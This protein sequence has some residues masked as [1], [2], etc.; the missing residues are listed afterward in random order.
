MLFRHLVWINLNCDNFKLLCPI[1]YHNQSIIIMYTWFQV[2]TLLQVNGDAWRLIWWWEGKIVLRT[3]QGGED[4]V[5]WWLDLKFKLEWT[6]KP[7]SW[8][9]FKLIMMATGLKIW[10]ND[11]LRVIFNE[12]LRV[13]GGGHHDQPEY[14]QA[15][16][17]KLLIRL[18][19]Q[20]GSTFSSLGPI[21]SVTNYAMYVVSYFNTKCNYIPNT[22][23]PI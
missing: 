12:G 9:G 6:L 3:L 20:E 19:V 1:F 22:Y 17:S 11:I 5:N 14:V 10:T 7:L 21:W 18:P 2:E 4:L 16:N 13:R 8:G 15:D 23:R